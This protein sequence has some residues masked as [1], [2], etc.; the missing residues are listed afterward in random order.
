MKALERERRYSSYSLSTSALDGGCLFSVTPQPCFSPGER[1]SSTHCTG[2]WVGPRA[3]LDTEA[4]GVILSPL[5]GIKL[6]SPGRPA[7]SL[8]LYRLSYLAHNIMTKLFTIFLTSKYDN[9]HKYNHLVVCE[10]YY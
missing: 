4:R 3:S 10:S 7:C 8:T 6:R 9:M 2:G 5:L 1:A